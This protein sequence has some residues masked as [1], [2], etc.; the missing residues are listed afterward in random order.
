MISDDLPSQ[1]IENT[2][3][4]TG[5]DSDVFREVSTFNPLIKLGL[6]TSTVPQFLLDQS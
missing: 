3:E 6:I 5:F 4:L 2:S 1:L